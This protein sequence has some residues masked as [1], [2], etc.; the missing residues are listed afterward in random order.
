MLKEKEDLLYIS[1]MFE[2]S[3]K[4]NPFK[5]AE[6]FYPVEMPYTMDETFILSMVVPAGYVVDELPK[7]IT[8]KLN[9]NDDGIFQYSISESGGTISV[10]SRIQLKRTYYLP[11]EYEILREF[12]NLVVKKQ[13][14]QI[15]LKKKK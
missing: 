9:E 8:V 4:E 15:V 3:W 13:N 1:P 7:S 11:D 14:E 10:R 6:R 12:F 5:S 2:E